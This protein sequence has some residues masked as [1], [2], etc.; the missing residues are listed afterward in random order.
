MRPAAQPCSARRRIGMEM[1]RGRRRE[2]NAG[3]EKETKDIYAEGGGEV[4][5]EIGK[6]FYD[7][8]SQP[9]SLMTANVGNQV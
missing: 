9:C 2:I 3:K 4:V 1:A 8:N 6:F 5:E 7:D